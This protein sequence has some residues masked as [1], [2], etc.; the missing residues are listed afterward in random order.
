MNQFT[1]H[2]IA[3]VAT[4]GLH[5]IEPASVGYDGTGRRIFFYDR[6]EAQAATVDGF[7]RDTLTVNPRAFYAAMHN[8]RCQYINR[9]R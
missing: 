4:L 1:T 8:V 3:L 6:T 2:S 7:F 9:P 5:G